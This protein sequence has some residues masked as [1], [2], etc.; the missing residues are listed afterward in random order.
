MDLHQYTRTIKVL[1]EWST[2]DTKYYECKILDVKDDGTVINTE[3]DTIAEELSGLHRLHTLISPF[4]SGL[5]R[6]FS[7]RL[8]KVAR[9]IDCYYRSKYFAFQKGVGVTA[10]ID[11]RRTGMYQWYVNNWQYKW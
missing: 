9:G 3:I 8:D 11:S 7:S 1:R 5:P 10:V 6:Y 4:R 2:S